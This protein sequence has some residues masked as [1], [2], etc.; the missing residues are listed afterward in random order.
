MSDPAFERL[1]PYLEQP[2]GQT[3]WVADENLLTTRINPSPL[4][5]AI[6]NRYDL[7]EN[8]KR[9]DWSALYSD[10]DFSVH[11]DASFDRVIYRI[12]KE[13]PV[14]HHL[15]NQAFRALKPG[16]QLLLA[17]AK[18]EGIKTY[19]SKAKALFG[20]GD[21]SKTAGD[22]WFAQLTKTS[23][24]MSALLDD[25]NY[26]RIR[27]VAADEQ[28][29]YFSKPGV[30]GWDKIDKGSAYLIEHLDQFLMTL[31]EPPRSALDL[32]CGYGYL[33]LNLSHLDIPV[34]ATDNNA[35][36][37]KACEYN[38]N[39]YPI[40]AQAVA[41]NCAEQIAKKFDLIVCNPPFHAGFSVD[42]DLTDRFLKAAHDHLESRGIA[43]FVTNL[44]IP[45][46]R[47]AARWFKQAEVIA[48]N[49]HFKL[50]RLS[51]GN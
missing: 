41:D 51:H 44:H 39:R 31:I 37:I 36:A 23:T 5:K 38:F 24:D 6:T 11:T 14:V 26:T 2:Q 49:G 8:L 42:G 27:A 12:S 33:S 7:A 16:G 45:L 40:D 30:F 32:G 35:A 29:E 46:E 25:Q 9:Q 20:E 28:F 47:K 21:C 17:G 50:I 3:L 22:I 43:C 1:R 34:T 4:L 10:Y 18:T 15:I 19:F 48:A 13:K